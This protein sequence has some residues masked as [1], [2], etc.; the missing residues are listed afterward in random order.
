[1]VSNPATMVSMDWML[2]LRL[3][4]AVVLMV[5]GLGLAKDAVLR[6]MHAVERIEV[7]RRVQV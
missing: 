7:E 3:L 6:L 1:M 5:R 4:T 2:G